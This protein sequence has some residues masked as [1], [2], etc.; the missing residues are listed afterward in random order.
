MTF[1][2]STAD[3][4]PGST[5]LAGL[6]ISRV[7]GVPTA[8]EFWGHRNFDTP[9][10]GPTQGVTELARARTLGSVGWEDFREYD[11]RIEFDTNSLKIWVDGSLEFDL[12]GSFPD[13]R[14]AF[15]NFSQ[16]QVT[17]SAFRIFSRY[18][19]A[20]DIRPAECPNPIDL[21]GGGVLPAAFL[22]TPDFDVSQIDPASIRLIDPAAGNLGVTPLQH[23][24]EDVATPFLPLSPRT[25]LLDCTAAGPDGYPDITLKFDTDEVLAALTPLAEGDVRVLKLSGPPVRRKPD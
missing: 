6:A 18:K 24:S 25:H 15:Y 14:L 22:G 17:Y 5:A 11:F 19:V 10:S 1:A 8:D 21:R 20:A 2:G 3:E 9:S 7:T 4:T 13:G 16:Q 12:S 23:A